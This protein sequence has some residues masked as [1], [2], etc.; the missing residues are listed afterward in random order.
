MRNR[1]KSETPMPHESGLTCIHAANG[2]CPDCE[3]DY[4]YD[5]IAWVEFGNHPQGIANWEAELKA[6]EEWQ[7]P[8]EPDPTI[9]F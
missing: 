8:S 5:P 4:D 3:A 9:P 6:I 2:L 7:Q 1:A